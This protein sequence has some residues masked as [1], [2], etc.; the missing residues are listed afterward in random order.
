MGMDGVL[1]DLRGPP[2]EPAQ[3][4]PIQVWEPPVL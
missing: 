1:L 2:Q 4:D 3:V